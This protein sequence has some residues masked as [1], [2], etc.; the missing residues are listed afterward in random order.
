MDYLTNYYKNL[1][2]QLQEKVNNLTKLLE[3]SAATSGK[4]QKTSNYI[5]KDRAV[6]I[7]YS[8]QTEIIKGGLAASLPL[9]NIGA[10]AKSLARGFAGGGAAT[11]GMMAGDLV[12]DAITSTPAWERRMDSLGKGTE[13][14]MS[15]MSPSMQD[16]TIK[17]LDVAY[18]VASA[19]RDPIG[20]AHDE[21]EAEKMAKIKKTAPA[22]QQE[23]D[24]ASAEARLRRAKRGIKTYD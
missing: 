10:R 13:R 1:S 19:V 18:D 9:Q 15:G 11:I 3:A 4:M 16:K 23:Y 17:A 7:P 6:P 5:L 22:T 2:E 8:A 21:I 24:V 12:A 14:A 20:Y